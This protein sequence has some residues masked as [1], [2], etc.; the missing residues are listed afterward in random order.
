MT[1]SLGDRLSSTDLTK[2]QESRVVL[3]GLS[4]LNKLYLIEEH[5]INCI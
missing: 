1:Y 4:E 2:L 3:H 5:K